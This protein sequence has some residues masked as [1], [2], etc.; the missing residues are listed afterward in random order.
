MP[1]LRGPSPILAIAFAAA[2]CQDDDFVDG[3]IRILVVASRANG[4]PVTLVR[5][6]SLGLFPLTLVNPF[7]ARWM[8]KSVTVEQ[9]SHT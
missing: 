3:P 6:L 5:P 2:V 9:T 1:D 7:E 4:I 8:E